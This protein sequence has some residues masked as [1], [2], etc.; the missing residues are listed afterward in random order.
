MAWSCTSWG[1]RQPQALPDE[2]NGVTDLDQHHLT[3]RACSLTTRQI[4]RDVGRNVLLNSFDSSAG[5]LVIA[6]LSSNCISYSLLVCSGSRRALGLPGA[7]ACAS[8]WKPWHDLKCGKA[9]PAQGY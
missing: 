5:S 8:C 1:G 4:S 6:G 9:Q 7:K 2:S 3:G